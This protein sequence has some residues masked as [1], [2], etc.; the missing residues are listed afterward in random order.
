MLAM[1]FLIPLHTFGACVR[2]AV[3]IIWLCNMQLIVLGEYVFWIFHLVPHCQNPRPPETSE[4]VGS[5]AASAGHGAA[6][7]AA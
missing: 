4:L 1:L 6:A 7:D 3:K 2:K 5:A